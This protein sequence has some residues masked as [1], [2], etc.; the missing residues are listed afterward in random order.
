M[1]AD[2]PT[3]TTLLVIVE[4]DKL[5]VEP[6]TYFSIFAPKDSALAFLAQDGF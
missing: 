4:L 1:S 5:L 3:L 6:Q 2:F